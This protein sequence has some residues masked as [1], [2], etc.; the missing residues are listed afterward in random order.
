MARIDSTNEMEQDEKEEKKQSIYV[1][2]K[3]LRK[4]LIVSAAAVLVGFV[5]VFVGFSQLLISFLSQPLVEL[6]VDIVTIGVAEAF[7]AQMRVSLV[8]GIILASPIIFWRIW[9]FLRPALY[10]KERG[11]FLFTFFVVVFLFLTGV[12]FAYFLVLGLAINFFIVTGEDIATPMISIDMY[13][14]MLFNF[15]IPFGLAFE[16]P[17]V[18]YVMHRLG[19]VTVAGLVKARKYV[20]FGMFVLATLITPP[21]LLSQILLALPLCI[22]YEISIIIL[23]IKGRRRTE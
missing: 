20:I 3:E 21:D 15:V 2:L 9:S 18:I 16:F 14:G 17:V 6:G 1:H 10:P 12:L 22:L 11:A 7:I 19:I 13:I 8:A 23:K 4:V 5:V